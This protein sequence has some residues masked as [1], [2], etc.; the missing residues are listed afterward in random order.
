MRRLVILALL[1]GA[2]KLIEPLGRPD[3]APEALLTFGFLILA[4]YATG[5]LA[6][7]F[8]LPKIVGYLVGGVIAGPSVLGTVPSSATAELAPVSS[9][10]IAMIAFLA[11]AELRWEEL[12][13]R[14]LILLR[15]TVSEIA[16]TFLAIA[17][18]LVAGRQFFP[19]LRDVPLTSAMIFAALFASI[20][21]VHSPAVTMAL[22]TETRAKG[23][24]ARTTLGIVLLSDVVVVLVF[25][26]TLALAQRVVPTAGTATGGMGIVVWEILGAVPIGAL[27]GFGVAQALRVIKGELLLFAL[28]AALFGQQVASLLHVE[29]LLT[30]LV[31]GFVAVNFAREE[32]GHAIL[33]A[34][35]RAAAPIFV[36]FFA[37]AGTKLDVVE[38]AL[39]APLVLPIFGVRILGI[40]GGLRLGARWAKVPHAE[41]APVW[42]GLVSQAGVAIGLVTIASD[43][44]P[45]AGDAMRTLLLALIAI[46]ETVGPILFR[47][48]LVAADEVEGNS[49]ES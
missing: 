10:A 39:L 12:R 21:V 43:V 11:G 14:G 22:L 23:P 19:F 1:F 41:V 31:A 37:L 46:N 32:Q 48:A 6:A 27:L 24:V 28:L 26:A 36:V 33:E 25:S 9:L 8:G 3:A 49:R 18:L 34:M 45:E 13:R 4:A 20:A 29:M 47:R 16:V 7:G 38:T 15:L 30:L 35:E 44:Y 42:Q 40:R 5:E 2:M 17:A